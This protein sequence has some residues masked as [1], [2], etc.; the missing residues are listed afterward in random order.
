MTGA[1]LDVEHL[2]WMDSIAQ[3]WQPCWKAPLP[4]RRSVVASVVAAAR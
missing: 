1:G 4:C 3:K 2:I